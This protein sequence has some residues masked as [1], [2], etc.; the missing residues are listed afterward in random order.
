MPTLRGRFMFVG[1]GAI[2]LT[3]AAAALWACSLVFQMNN[4]EPPTAIDLG[5]PADR[6]YLHIAFSPDGSSLV[7]IGGKR[8]AEEGIID[9]WD[10]QK[11]EIVRSLTHPGS[12]MAAVFTPDGKRLITGARDTRKQD[13]KSNK[14]RIYDG[15]KWELG[16]EFAADP[17]EERPRRLALLRDGKHLLSAPFG[18]G[19]LRIWNLDQ[20][21][22]KS[23]NAQKK[24]ITDVAVF[25]DCERFAVVYSFLI[26]VWDAKKLEPIGTFQVK[27]NTLSIA[28]SSD[29]KWIATGELDSGMTLWD[30]STLKVSKELKGASYYPEAIAFT[31]DSKLLVGAMSIDDD[32]PEAKVC[33]WSTASGRLLQTFKVPKNAATYLALSPDNRWLVTMSHASQMYLWDFEKIRKQLGE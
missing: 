22:Q 33:I 16:H 7:A 28:F 21:K 15:P 23:L 25:P 11:K 12:V 8:Q 3:F 13:P 30:A 20:R 26:E 27:T 10:L 31:N 32:F 24:Q 2:A 5:R 14:F 6:D 1:L 4:P 18:I 17:V 29:K 19:I 9:F